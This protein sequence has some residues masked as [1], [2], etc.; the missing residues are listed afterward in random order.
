MRQ[1]WWFFA[2]FVLVGAALVT[3]VA[4]T[5]DGEFLR[6]FIVGS[7][8]VAVVGGAAVMVLMLSGT[9][10][11]AMGATAEQWTASELRPLRKHGWVV[12]NHLLLRR[13]DIDHVL[14]GPNGVVAVESKWSGSGWQISPPSI[15]V[16]EAIR[17]VKQDAHDLALWHPIRKHGNPNAQAV[18][19]LWDVG[20][21]AV[22]KREHPVDID[23]VTVITGVKAAE[24]WRKT[25]TGPAVDATFTPE[26]V[27][28]IWRD[29]EAQAT[30]RDELEAAE[31][32]PP[33]YTWM[34][35]NGVGALLAV[36]ASLWLTATLAR[37]PAWAFA[38]AEI[39]A[40]VA[41]F[42]GRRLRALRIASLGW[43]AVATLGLGIAVAAAVL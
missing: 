4:L 30:K 1:S 35:W 33:S 38:S 42:A 18:L 23:G 16:V 14:V 34:F 24:H 13:H 22:P 28:A 20:N 2:G 17:R 12:V 26:Y 36:I 43:I 37:L 25:L 41:A 3:G 7:G 40:L 10:A 19:F 21:V 11:T 8:I 32:P 31:P 6:G 15:F 9:A 5:V 29:L 39:L 27:R